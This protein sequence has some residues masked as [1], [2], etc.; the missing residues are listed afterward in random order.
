MKKISIVVPCFN[1]EEVIKYFYDEINNV[2][3]D[4]KYSLEVIFIDDG[5]EDNT[6]EVIKDYSIKD[7]RIKYLS[8]SRNFGKESSIYAGLSYASGD[9]ACIMDVDLQDPPKLLIEMINILESDSNYDIV[10]SRRVTRSGEP[11]VRSFFARMFYKIINKMSKTEMVDGARDFCLMRKDVYQNIVNMNEYN[12]YF[13]GMISFVGYRVKWLEYENV[14]RVAGTTKWSFWKLFKYA[15]EGIV[16]YT[17]VPLF[18]TFVFSI[19]FGLLSIIILIISII[20]KLEFVYY[21]L[22][23]I[24]FSFALVFLFIGI[25][26]LYLSKTYLE[27]KNRPMYIVR[28]TN[29]RRNNDR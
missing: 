29:M 13:K 9:Y 23:I 3:K 15:M 27:V 18:F 28:D 24:L 7:N 12:R 26:G 19:L 6:L 14:K 1:E 22:S 10:G 21:S 25:I 11:P 17:T 4:N 2:F 16:A 20:N 8:F 5:S